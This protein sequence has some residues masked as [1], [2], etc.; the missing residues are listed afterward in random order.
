[1]SG[2]GGPSASGAEVARGSC[3]CGALRY[4]VTGPLRPVVACHCVMCR[5]TS[6]HFVAATAAR[7]EHVTI[8]GKARWY[9]SSARAER[10]FCPTCGSNLFWRSAGRVSLWAGSLDAAP[11]DLRLAGHIFCGDKGAYYEITDGLPQAAGDDPDLA[12]APR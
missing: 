3:L 10:G 1:M 2:A 5:K 4:R 8:T 9:R 11:A 12:L 7:E 6:G